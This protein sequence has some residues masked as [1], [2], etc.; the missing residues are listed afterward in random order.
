LPEFGRDTG[1]LAPHALIVSI[2]WTMAAA[3]PL[4]AAVLAFVSVQRM[5][6]PAIARRNTRLLLARGAVEVGRGH[7]PVMVSLH[8]AW[9][10]GLWLLAPARDPNLLLLTVFGLLQAARIWL[11]LVLGARWTTRIIVLPSAPLVRSGPYRFLRH[12]NYWI[13][14]AEI[15]VLPLVFGLPAFA[16]A[17]SLLNAF[18]LRV[19]IRAEDAA[20]RRGAEPA[21]ASASHNARA[22]QMIGR[23]HRRRRAQRQGASAAS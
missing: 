5:A 21:S 9:L 19:R 2:D 13:V 18:L 20:L 1:R 10:S 8:A 17:F 3:N 6:E 12:P 22:R 16:V 23:R 4:S 14:A 15:L 7:Y 11:L